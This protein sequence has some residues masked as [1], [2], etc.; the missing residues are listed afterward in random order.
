MEFLNSKLFYPVAQFILLSISVILQTTFSKVFFYSLSAR[1]WPTP[2]IVPL[3]SLFI[4][5][6][7]ILTIMTFCSSS[8]IVK[9][10]AIDR[11]SLSSL[12]VIE[13]QTL[14]KVLFWSSFVIWLS[15]NKIPRLLSFMLI[16]LLSNNDRIK[17]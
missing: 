9:W 15:S 14:S 2:I 4:V 11:I 17:A 16:L 5:K 13:W 12:L 7:Q 6:W 10:Q 8:S 3:L 1:K